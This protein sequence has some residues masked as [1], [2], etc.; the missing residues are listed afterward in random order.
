[1]SD[2]ASDTA[3]DTSDTVSDELQ[4][5]LQ[6]ALTQ[7]QSIERIHYNIIES[8]NHIRDNIAD[9]IYIVYDEQERDFDTVLNELHQEALQHVETTG[10]H[11]FGPMLLAIL[12]KAEFKY[13]TSII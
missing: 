1:M 2:T 4:Q 10:H 12:A 5:D 7:C 11:P 3:S 9:T 8:L 6:E 13:S